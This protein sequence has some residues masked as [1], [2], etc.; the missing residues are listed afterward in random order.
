MSEVFRKEIV[1]RITRT[2]TDIQILRLLRVEPLWGYRIKRKVETDL[3]VKVRHG[4]LYPTLNLLETR[5]FVT[6]EKQQH[7]G[8]ARKVYTITEDGKKY[9]QSYY[10]IIRE[11]LATSKE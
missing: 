9:L 6:S 10:A 2:L 7:D 4:T 1:Q 3:D 5:G 11:H 8:R